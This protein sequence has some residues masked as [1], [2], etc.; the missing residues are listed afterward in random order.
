M[1]MLRVMSM[2]ESHE[3]DQHSRS[4]L[5]SWHISC[6]SWRAISRTECFGD[7]LKES[8]P[9]RATRATEEMIAARATL[10]SM[11][12]HGQTLRTGQDAISA[13]PDQNTSVQW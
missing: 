10:A 4:I 13:F 2:Q 9:A 11:A 6:G 5:P 8:Q 12:H 1:A 7:V 3:P